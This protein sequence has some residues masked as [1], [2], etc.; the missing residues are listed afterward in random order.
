[1]SSGHHVSGE[2]VRDFIWLFLGDAVFL[3]DAEDCLLLLSVLIDVLEP[4][5][6]SKTMELSRECSTIAEIEEP[7]EISL[8]RKSSRPRM[9]DTFPAIV[10]K[11]RD[12]VYSHGFI[13]ADGKANQFVYEEN[14]RSSSVFCSTTSRCDRQK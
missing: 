7:D 2:Y 9:T 4:P 6:E 11:I 10:T 14:D 1:M 3:L 12:F 13:A 5:P 8:A